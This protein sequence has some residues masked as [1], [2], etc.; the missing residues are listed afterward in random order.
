[1]QKHLLIFGSNGALGKGVTNVLVEKDY[2][3]F[4]L[5]DSKP[6]ELQGKN[7]EKIQLRDLSDEQNVIKAFDT[8]KPSRG[9]EYFLFTT[10]G[11]FTGGKNLWETEIN[12][13]TKMLDSNLKTCFFIGKYFARLVK[14]SAG[15]S[16]LFTS[17]LTGLFPEKGNIPYGISKNSVIYLTKSLALEGVSINLSANAIAPYIIDTPANR[18]WM[19]KDYDYEHLIKPEE[20]GEVVHSVFLNFRVISGTVIKLPGRLNIKE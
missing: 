17:A 13:L 12:D 14:N 16:I 19:G 18:E 7:I 4:Y 10:V 6:N 8:I 15:G 1:M 2:D 11:G 3:K 9:I 20:I 5:F